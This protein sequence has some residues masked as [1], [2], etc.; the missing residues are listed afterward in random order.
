MT[1]D[2]RYDVMWDHLVVQVVE[3]SEEVLVAMASTPA[4][5]EVIVW[6]LN[7]AGRPAE[8][9]EL[10][11]LPEDVRL[12]LAAL[13]AAH[14]AGADGMLAPLVAG[15]LLGE[16]R[17]SVALDRDPDMRTHSYPPGPEAEAEAVASVELDED[18]AGACTAKHPAGSPGVPG[19]IATRGDE[20]SSREYRSGHY[21]AEDK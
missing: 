20:T 13:R 19:V 5:A 8:P 2:A 18:P 6:A 14:N 4:I 12:H 10:S 3:G 17:V 7:N 1:E 9:A 16:A 21:V 15:L 11:E